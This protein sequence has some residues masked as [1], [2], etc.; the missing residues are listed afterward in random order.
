MCVI[1]HAAIENFAIRLNW[2]SISRVS[3]WSFKL[4]L[5]MNNSHLYAWM[6][7]R[8]IKCWLH[9]SLNQIHM[10]INQ[11]TEWFS[12]FSFRC[13]WTYWFVSDSWSDTL[14]ALWTLAHISRSVYDTKCTFPFVF[15]QNLY[16]FMPPYAMPFNKL[17]IQPDI[18]KSSTKL[19]R[20]NKLHTHVDLFFG[21]SF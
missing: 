17:F 2:K 20:K 7:S 3:K 8:A 5:L 15:A 9:L 12:S 11:S 14:R 10:R 19:R 21:I 1:F 18:A 13:L 16:L 4:F 6:E